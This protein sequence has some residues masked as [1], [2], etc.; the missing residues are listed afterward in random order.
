VCLKIKLGLLAPPSPPD[1][2]PGAIAGAGD[3]VAEDQRGKLLTQ[4][5]GKLLGKSRDLVSLLK[6]NQRQPVFKDDLSGCI[7][8]FAL[9][10]S[11]F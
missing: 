5:S 10:R 4:A 6:L 2:I 8:R 3:V 9:A 1:R 7:N 11:L